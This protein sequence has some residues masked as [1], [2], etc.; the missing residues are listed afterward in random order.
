MS[1]K[2]QPPAGSPAS[3][4]RPDVR[5]EDAAVR[6]TDDFVGASWL[7][8]NRNFLLFLVLVI[9]V[10][11]LASDFVPGFLAARKAESWTR[12]EEARNRALGGT[13]ED[14]RAALE[15]LEDDPELQPWLAANAAQR[16][17]LQQDREVLEALLPVL[18]DPDAREAVAAF[19]VG[20]SQENLLEVLADRARQILSEPSEDERFRNPEPAGPRAKITVTVEGEGSYDIIVGLYPDAA[21]ETVERFLAAV[22]AG[23]L[24][25]GEAQL[26]SFQ[27]LS[28]EGLAAGAEDPEPI[29]LERRWGY[30]HR[31]GTLSTRQNP[32]ADHGGQFPDT[33]LLH[34]DPMPHLDGLSNVFGQVV[35][36]EEHLATLKDL[37][38]SLQPTDPDDPSSK[39]A[40]RVE[41]VEILP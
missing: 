8:E 31:A 3:P 7:R 20:E 12:F 26:S 17:L 40:V 24:T 35:E 9:L 30:F 37:A 13:L 25:A 10:V 11:G 15:I 21:P 14:V 32:T 18:E 23:T 36:G 29:P 1:P 27:G 4:P 2:T 33:V 39:P 41:S 16:A 6:G 5:T 34:F 38:G 28:F 22:E 19:P